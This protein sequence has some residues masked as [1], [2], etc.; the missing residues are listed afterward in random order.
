LQHANAIYTFVL[1]DRLAQLQS[2]RRRFAIRLLKKHILIQCSDALIPDEIP[3]SAMANGS[4]IRYSVSVD[5]SRFA[6][7][8]RSARGADMV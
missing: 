8:S 1:R 6:C 4:K 3:G 2:V 7:S 5:F